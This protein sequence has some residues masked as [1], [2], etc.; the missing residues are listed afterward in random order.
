M[1]VI[2]VKTDIFHKEKKNNIFEYSNIMKKQ[3]D[4][5]Q[6]IY[7]T[8]EC[9]SENYRYT[10]TNNTIKVDKKMLIK[11][12]ILIKSNLTDNNKKII[13]LLNKLTDD[14]KDKICDML[15][16]IIDVSNIDVFLNKMLE[17]R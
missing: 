11:K 10:P 7:N 16:A 1:Q 2:Q 15:L 8:Y 5:L 17:Y 3:I 13:Q 6:N 4:C 12:P 9:F 14:N